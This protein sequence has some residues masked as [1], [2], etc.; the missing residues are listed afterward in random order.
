M[1]TFEPFTCC[2]CH[3]RIA[4]VDDLLEACTDSPGGWHHDE[5]LPLTQA[6]TQGLTQGVG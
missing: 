2:Y 4:S 6:P 3:E 5:P 1:K